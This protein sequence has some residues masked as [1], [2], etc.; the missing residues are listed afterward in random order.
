[1]ALW[2]SK[3][4]PM[5]KPRY[6][7]TRALLL[8]GLGAVYVM[9]FGSLA[10]Q[11]DGLIGSQGI[12]PAH[13]FLERV[14]AVLGRD[15]YWQLPTVFWLGASD[16][17]LRAV[18][19]GGVV[20]GAL[21]TAGLLPRAG[22]VLLWAGYL[23]LTT[24][25]Q[26]FLGYQWDSL[27]LE[28]GL[29]GV[30]LAP[31]GLWLGSARSRVPVPIEVIWL[32]R[33]LVFRLMFLSGVV[34]VRSGDP[35]WASWDAL[36][37]HYETQPIPSW[38]S[39]YVHQM[40]PWFHKAS[41]GFMF[42]AELVAPFLIF[43]PRPLRW[44]AF[45]STV[46][47]QLNIAAT[48][49]YGFFNILSLVLC[50]ALLDDRDWGWMA[51]RLGTRA[52]PEPET[53]PDPDASKPEPR[54]LWTTARRWGLRAAAALIFAITAMQTVEAVGLSLP[55]PWPLEMV[56]QW[57]EPFRSLNNYGLFAVMTTER[58]EVEVEGSNDGVTWAPYQ[59]R[60]KA[61]EVD[62]RPRFTTP[63]LP[64]L[65]W[66]MW[67]AALGG[68]CARSPWFLWFEQRLLEGSPPVLALLRDDPFPGRPPRL[69]RAR[70]AL[71]RFTRPGSRAWWERQEAGLFCPPMGMEFP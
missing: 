54:T 49:N 60:W 61:G 69:I 7:A 46:M 44:A 4:D 18:C 9:A 21:V 31:G 45:A 11:V 33:W 53:W 10:V 14:R 59:F 19:W 66:Q 17:A 47:L 52:G 8:R 12:L 34:K 39:W 28:A 42:W 24:V 37:Y 20:V 57:A 15:A 29:L 36:R 22:L 67:F 43:G 63:H 35:A 64:R 58:P 32:F 23:S 41:V 2:R 68:H 51:R 5:A 26:D 3:T 50:A 27:L 70:L 62:R 65:D 40:P 71:Y 55:F 56:R 6:A 30:L 38:T 25:G 16:T 48:G 1:M 13:D